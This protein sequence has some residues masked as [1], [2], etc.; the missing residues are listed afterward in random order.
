MKYLLLIAIVLVVI[1]VWRNGR[2]RDVSQTR[3]TPP[4]AGVA[5]EI[6]ACAVCQ[7]HLPRAEA[8]TGPGGGTY[9]CLAHRRQAGG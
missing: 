1:G 7:V 9:C 4:P 2:R 6:V 3:K 5:T 8:L